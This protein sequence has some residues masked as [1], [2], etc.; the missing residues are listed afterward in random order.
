[1]PESYYF[2]DEIF[3]TCRIVSV[4]DSEK[5]PKE[6]GLDSE[7]VLEK[8][9]CQRARSRPRGGF[10]GS[11]KPEGPQN[12]VAYGGGDGDV[13][14]FSSLCLCVFMCVYRA[15]FL[16]VF[17]YF[18]ANASSDIEIDHLVYQSYGAPSVFHP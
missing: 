8:L 14:V 7:E 17:L 11:G 5:N 10:L 3:V 15:V 9:E 12:T 13:C 2:Y 6:G 1:M 16:R 4:V 18:C